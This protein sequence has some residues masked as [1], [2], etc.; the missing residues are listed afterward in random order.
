MCDEYE[1]PMDEY[2]AM[3]IEQLRVATVDH[4]EPTATDLWNACIWIDNQ[5]RNVMTD[6]SSGVFIHCKGGHGRGAAM[7]FAWYYSLFFFLVWFFMTLG[8]CVCFLIGC[9]TRI[10]MLIHKQ[11]K[12]NY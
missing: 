11:F 3:G 2:R 6:P 1:G 12:L 7:A 5:L 9:Y 4:I 10:P 8:T